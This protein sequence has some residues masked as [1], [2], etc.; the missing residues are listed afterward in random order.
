M[1]AIEIRP[2]AQTVPAGLLQDAERDERAVRCG[3]WSLRFSDGRLDDLRFGT[4]RILRGVR[5]VVR[6]EDWGTF[7]TVR[8]ALEIEGG[9][10]VVEGESAQGEARVTWTLRADFSGNSLT[11]ALEA[12]ASTPFLRNRLGLIVLHGTES[13]GATVE[14]RH[15]GGTTDRLAFPE[16]IAPHQPAQDLAGLAWTADGVPVELTLEGDVFETEDQRNWTDASF[17]TYSTPLS[18][19][20]PVP[21]AAGEIVRQSLRIDCGGAPPTV[22]RESIA[23][24]SVLRTGRAGY[25]LPEIRTSAASASTGLRPDVRPALDLL[26]ECDVRWTGWR[27]ALQRAL[28]DAGGRP[29]D[30]RVVASGPEDVR[31]VLDELGDAP[32]ARLGVFAAQGHRSTPELLEA[33]R[34][35]AAERGAEV[36][37]G[38]RSHFTELNRGADAL[39]NGE[40]SLAFSITP[41]MHDR[42]GHQLV[43]SLGVQRTVVRDAAAIADGRR[44]HIGP[45]TLGARMNAVSTSPFDPGAA[46]I[47]GSGYGPEIVPGATDERQHAPEFAAWVVGSV[48]ALAVPGVASLA[49]FEQWGPRGVVTAAGVTAAGTVL[50]W[51][52]ALTGS[53]RLDA[54]APG[55]VALGAFAADRRVVLLGNAGGTAVAVD[56]TGIERWE[57][58]GGADCESFV[59]EPGGAARVLLTP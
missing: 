41:F 42:S 36:V 51:A 53:P 40:A 1:P 37:G 35:A 20:F 31:T 9:T 10:L 19:P 7:A 32:L 27:R 54:D 46:D 33:A 30:L 26:V 17:K 48:G 49:Y 11:I 3:P 4:A 58:A 43:E 14:A 28:E 45:V 50:Q 34:R 6:D 39:A 8:A 25:P 44:L 52:A 5:F 38:V 12:R 22:T 59:L 23:S 56:P 2:A 55:L 24:P 47:D 15:P 57:A 21:V 18:L 16:R 29:V 13:A